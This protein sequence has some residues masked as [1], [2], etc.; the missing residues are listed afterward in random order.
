MKARS[1]TDRFYDNEGLWCVVLLALATLLSFFPILVLKDGGSW[2]FF[3]LLPLWLITYFF[4]FRT[5]LIGSFMFSICKLIATF[6]SEFMM[7]RNFT[8][9]SDA[10]M[11]RESFI[12]GPTVFIL[13][14]L[15]ACTGF[16]LG[17]LL[18]SNIR[19]HRYIAEVKAARATR[20]PAIIDGY[21]N[22]LRKCDRMKLNI[23]G[24]ITREN[25]AS[26]LIFGYLIGV[27]VMFVCYVLAAPYYDSYP[28]GV[29]SKYARLLYDIKYDGSYLLVEA[30]TTVLVLLIP[31][32]RDIIF[33]LKHIANNPK[34]DP[35]VDSF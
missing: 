12:K 6:V 17:G 24:D 5:G 1:I 15:V 33:R 21:G 29:T 30:V 22:R 8:G 31:P 34:T 26:G 11:A 19:C 18:I 3:S 28:A 13:E 16:C 2:T 14:Y 27:A 10:E 32:V 9:P 23:S 25:S 20:E 4:G 35:T 7:D